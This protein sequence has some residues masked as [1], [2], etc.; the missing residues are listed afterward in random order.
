MLTTTTYLTGHLGATNTHDGKVFG[1]STSDLIAFYGGAPIA[2]LAAAAQA[3][4]TDGSV[5]TANTTTGVGA[6]TGTYN[7]TL[8]VNAI[9]TLVAQ[10]NALRAAMVSLNLIK[11]SA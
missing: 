1:N 4:I 2:R 5:G 9:A 3:V 11:G 10:G 6:L 7:S 8:I